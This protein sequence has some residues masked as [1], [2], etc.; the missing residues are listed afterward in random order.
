MINLF[1]KLYDREKSKYQIIKLDS[2]DFLIIWMLK[3]IST[4]RQT[5][6]QTFG[7][8]EA[9]SRRLKIRCL[10]CMMYAPRVQNI[11]KQQ[12]N[13]TLISP[14]GGSHPF[15]KVRERGGTLGSGA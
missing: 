3:K 12:H 1:K 14:G 9:T 7:L 13:P 8:I 10:E 2:F 4:P 6:R 11:P 15:P 5:D